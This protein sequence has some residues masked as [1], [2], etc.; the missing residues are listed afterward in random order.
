MAKTKVTKSSPLESKNPKDWSPAS[1]MAALRVPRKKEE[2]IAALKR[3][4]ILTKDGTLS[5]RFK[6]GDKHHVTRAQDLS[7]SRST[8]RKIKGVGSL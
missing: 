6:R 4:G 8:R 5:P 2:R 7:S 3:S 1:L